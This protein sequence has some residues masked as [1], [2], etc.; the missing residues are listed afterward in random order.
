[1]KYLLI[2]ISLLI[3][4]AKTWAQ[5]GTTPVL[6]D[7]I[8]VKINPLVGTTVG[9]GECWDL[10]DYLL[11]AVQA[12]WT[13][14]YTYGKAVDPKKEAIYPGDM[15][16]LE[17]IQMKYEKDGAFYT[18]SMPHH[19]AVVYEVLANGE[20][21]I[22]HQNNGYTGRKVGISDFKLAWVKKGKYFFYRPQK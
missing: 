21:K 10:A 6:N 22:A 16:Q 11:T 9:R 5:S 14:P 1:M 19:T 3:L 13:P 7:S 17:N 20:Y 2:G 4:H 12:K 15:I 8:R 18:E